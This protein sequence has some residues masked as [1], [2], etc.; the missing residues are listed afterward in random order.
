MFQAPPP[1]A[2][3]RAM[4]MTTSPIPVY[5][6]SRLNMARC[7]LWSHPP[8]IQSLTESFVKP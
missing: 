5:Y 3:P 8:P 6:D 4:G 2:A 7:K 1:E